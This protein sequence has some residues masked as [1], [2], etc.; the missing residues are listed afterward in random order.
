MNINL[1]SNNIIK[2][3]RLSSLILNGN[4]TYKLFIEKINIV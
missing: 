3:S 2:F 4:I 1:L